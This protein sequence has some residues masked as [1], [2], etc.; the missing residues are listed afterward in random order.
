MKG[1][2]SVIRLAAT[3]IGGTAFLSAVGGVAQAQDAAAGGKVFAR[4]QACHQVDPAKGSGLGPN[5][6]GVVGRKA[7][8][9]PRFN[10]S[11][12]MAKS[13]V[14]WDKA[15][16]DAFLAAPQKTLPGSRMAFAGL[17]NPKDRADVI[18]FLATKK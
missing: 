2:K 5:L 12:A 8:T 15:R 16:L 6:A 4:C 14:V 7:G 11:P 3:I 10:F 13:G 17:A 18:A 9:L 1:T